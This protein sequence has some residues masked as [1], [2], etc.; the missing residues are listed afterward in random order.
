MIKKKKNK[1]KKK[2]KKKIKNK[3]SHIKFKT[4]NKGSI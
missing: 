3:G 2:K 4:N 1:K